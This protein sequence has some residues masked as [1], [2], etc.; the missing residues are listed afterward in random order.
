[1][2]DRRHLARSEPPAEPTPL[3][4]APAAPGPSPIDRLLEQVAPA[5]TSRPSPAPPRIALVRGVRLSG[6]DELEVRVRRDSEPLRA[7]IAEELDREL[8]GDAIRDGQ[9][10]LAEWPEQGTPLVVGVVQTRRASRLRFS[11]DEITL[12]ASRELLLRSGAAALRLRATGDVELVG[13]RISAVSRGVMR[14]I[15]RLLRLN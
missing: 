4:A 13:S 8:L 7:E 11:A 1:M 3:E 5:P 14:L 6:S 9:L 15:G 2:A 12:D 10:L